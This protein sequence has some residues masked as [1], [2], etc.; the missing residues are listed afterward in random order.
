MRC[1]TMWVQC[2]GTSVYREHCKPS[3]FYDPM[4]QR[5]YK[6]YP[7]IYTTLLLN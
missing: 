2:E 6:K 1:G 5:D 7:S 4:G 3:L